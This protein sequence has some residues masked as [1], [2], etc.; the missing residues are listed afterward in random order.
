MI[1]LTESFKQ[2]PESIFLFDAFGAFVSLLSLLIFNF[3]TD[4]LNAIPTHMKVGLSV[5]ICIFVCCGIT[6]YFLAKSISRLLTIVIAYNTLY[7]VL[8]CSL[9]IVFFD[10]LKWIGKSYLIIEILILIGVVIFERYFL[11]LNKKTKNFFRLLVA[12]EY[13]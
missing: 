8:S 10:E 9:L 12:C 5:L 7:M 1:K 6:F 3:L 4:E 11:Y 2:K 13:G